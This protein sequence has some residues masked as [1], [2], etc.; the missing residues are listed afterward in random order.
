MKAIASITT[1]LLATVG[2]VRAVGPQPC[3]NHADPRNGI[4]NYC[5]CADNTCWERAADTDC[6]PTSQ[7]WINC[8]A[9]D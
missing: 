6:D 9:A 5:Q 1:V 2:A 7:V 3:Y 4:A 8:P